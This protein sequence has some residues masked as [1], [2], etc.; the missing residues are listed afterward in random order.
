MLLHNRRPLSKVIQHFRFGHP[1]SVES[2]VNEALN[3]S[4]EQPLGTTRKSIADEKVAPWDDPP[5]ALLAL[6]RNDPRPATVNRENRPRAVTPAIDGI[7]N[8]AVFPCSSAG[9]GLRRRAGS[10]VGKQGGPARPTGVGQVLRPKGHT[11]EV[12]FLTTPSC[13][14]FHGQAIPPMPMKVGSSEIS[15]G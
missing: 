5:Q 3:P 15:D 13:F 11:S 1:R 4:D 9:R 12:L 10:R 14:L 8:G 7:F 6:R 2:S